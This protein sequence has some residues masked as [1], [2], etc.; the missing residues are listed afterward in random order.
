[1]APSCTLEHSRILYLGTRFKVQDVSFFFVLFQ[2]TMP[3]SKRG[4]K[5]VPI[6]ADAMKKAVEAVTAPPDQR[7]SIREACKVYNVKLAT[8]SRHLASFKKSGVE[9]YNYLPN[10]DV[11]RVFSDEEENLLVTYIENVAKMN[12][13]LTK[14][15]VRQLAYRFAIANKKKYPDKWDADKIAGEEWMRCFMRRHGNK[16]SIRKPEATSLSRLTSFNKTNID[17]FF[18]NLEDVHRRFGPIPPHRIWNIDETGLST[19]QTP[20]SVVAPKGVKQIG[21]CTSAERGTLTTMIVAINAIGNHIPPMLIFP[22]VFFKERMVFGAPPGTVGAASP[23]GWSNEQMFLK[24]LDHF[25][26]YV[27]CSKDQRVLLVLDNHETH[28]SVEAVDRASEVG[29]VMVTFPP[30]TSHKLQPLDL[31]VYG[32]L[33]TFYNQCVDEWL[34]NHPGQTFSI[35]CVAEVLGTA[36][37]RA[38]STTNI[39]NGFKKPGIFPIDRGVFSD[40]D[41]LS[42]Y[43]TDRNSPL[44]KNRTTETS[45]SA[46]LDMPH[47]S[48]PHE[49][50][51]A[52]ISNSASIDILHAV[53]SNLLLT[54]NKIPTSET[55]STNVITP[56]QVQ[57]YPK[58]KPRTAGKRGRKTG[59]TRIV[60]DTPEKEQLRNDK[61]KKTQKKKVSGLFSNENH[62][63][64]QG[65]RQECYKREK[66]SM[67][68]KGKKEIRQRAHS[69]SFSS[70]GDDAVPL[71][72]TD[73]NH[74]ADEE[75]IYCSQPYREDKNGEGWIRC[76]NCLQWCHELC[77]GSDKHSWKTYLCD[78]CRPTKNFNT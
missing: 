57:P 5:R 66:T 11:N 26:S 33:K 47:S 35:Y 19:V 75:C 71:V 18:N 2:I 24:F 56:E 21:S 51:T 14:K 54:P 7:I 46:S 42:S 59:K 3:R 10:C 67:L 78:F 52:E 1:M 69:S 49:N 40:D 58:A 63:E 31:T 36:F 44:G 23:S 12:Y 50:A 9:T 76:L 70:V 53:P 43:V 28:L 4:V 41:F 17:S 45:I 37:P 15:G 32:P 25:I 6:N 55:K 29:I 61:N 73:D 64:P 77:A 8:L 60:T 13:G 65:S 34:V 38:F 72:S 62:T 48:P 20:A 68:V 74:S 22:R 39:V 30:H 27:K 16:L